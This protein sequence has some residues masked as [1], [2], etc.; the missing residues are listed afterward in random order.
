MK[1]ATYLSTQRGEAARPMRQAALPAEENFA[2]FKLY[3]NPTTGQVSLEI[4]QPLDGPYTVEVL[5]LTGRSVY[6][7]RFAPETKTAVLDLQGLQAG[8]YLCRVSQG[9][10]LIGVQKVVLIR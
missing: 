8:S 2:G 6:V 1:P 7:Q 4:A 5:D 9:R 10:S 3:P